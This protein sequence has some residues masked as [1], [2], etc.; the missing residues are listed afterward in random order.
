[1]PQNEI[2]KITPEIIMDKVCR[3]YTIAKEDLTGKIRTSNFAVPRQVAMYLCHKLTDMNFTTIGRSFGN[4]DR[5]T[6]MHNVRKIESDIE[7]NEELKSAIN[8][9]IKDLQTSN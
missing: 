9:I 8:Y 4:K 7:T 1:M 3:F 2:A 6:V 5:T